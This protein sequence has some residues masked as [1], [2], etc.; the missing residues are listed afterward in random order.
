MGP[1]EL[2][3]ATELTADV[4]IPSRCRRRRQIHRAREGNLQ[5]D[6]VEWTL[7]ASNTALESHGRDADACGNPSDIRSTRLVENSN[8]VKRVLI[9]VL[10]RKK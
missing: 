10:Q 4:P 1:R 3:E 2:P 9:L 7:H 5:P 8:K 6:R